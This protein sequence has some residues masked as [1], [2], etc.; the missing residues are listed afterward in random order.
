MDLDEN[1]DFLVKSSATFG[2][3]E[4][5][6]IEFGDEDNP[7]IFYVLENEHHISVV[8]LEN[9]YDDI[10]VGEKITEF[11]KENI[12]E[13]LFNGKIKGYISLSFPKSENGN[14][15]IDSVINNLTNVQKY[16]RNWS[17]V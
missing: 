7:K 6:N 14:K 3:F 13:D 9:I 4:V 16:L 12:R 10:K 15:A 2:D 1:L 17:N 8:V 5:V 11:S